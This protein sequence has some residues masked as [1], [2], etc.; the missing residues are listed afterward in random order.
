MRII[1]ST[2]LLL[3]LQGLTLF[4]EVAAN[5][6]GDLEVQ[7]KA[8]YLYKFASYV[9]WPAQSFAQSD[10]PV[11]IGVLGADEIGE[12]LSNLK[13][14]R[15]S[16]GRAVAVKILTAGESLGESL[17]GVQ[18]LFIGRRESVRVRKL[19]ESIQSQAVLIVTET[20]G[21]VA[22]GSIINFVPVDE[23][24][25]FEVSVLNAE[26]RGLKISA[27]LLAVAQKI[28]TGRP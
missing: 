17:R 25:R 1:R 4:A 27:R 3:I 2:V 21:A 7:I 20:A 28:E 11:T 14:L 26:R 13:E 8:T 16:N 5:E 6:P 22:V 10:A 19:S 9:E 15:L 23:R 18:I 12:A 24:I